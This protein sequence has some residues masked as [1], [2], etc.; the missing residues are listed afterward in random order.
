MCVQLGGKIKRSKLKKNIKIADLRQLVTHLFILDENK[1]D[2]LLFTYIEE[3]TEL[4]VILEEDLV[5]MMDSIAE[6]KTIVTIFCKLE[7]AGTHH[8]YS[9]LSDALYEIL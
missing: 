9:R 5:E 2:R 3:G 8:R 7:E 4:E 6:S 1:S